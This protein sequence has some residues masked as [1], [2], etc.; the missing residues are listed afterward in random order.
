MQ[1]LLF[2]KTLGYFQELA[3]PVLVEEVALV[4]HL[5]GILINSQTVL[6][7]SMRRTIIE[8]NG[9]VL[10]HTKTVP[11]LTLRAIVE[12]GGCLAIFDLVTPHDYFQVGGI[13]LREIPRFTGHA[14]EL[15]LGGVSPLISRKSVV[16]D[17]LFFVHI[18]RPNGTIGGKGEFV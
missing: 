8:D 4:T 13:V 16:G 6:V 15:H 7:V 5:A 12:P 9:V 3:I 2:I 11:V 14:N 1:T 18:Y 17:Y 10:S